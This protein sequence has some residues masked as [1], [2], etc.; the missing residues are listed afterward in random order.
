[1]IR[2][3]IFGA[4]EYS[5]TKNDFAW[6]DWIVSRRNISEIVTLP[7]WSSHMDIEDWYGRKQM[8]WWRSTSL[9]GAVSRCTAAAM[10][11]CDLDTM[12]TVI[13]LQRS[14]RPIAQRKESKGR[15]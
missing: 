8:P 12:A 2:L 11:S 7:E 13:A 4:A 10:V 5:L 9:K 15:K 14:G 3:L 6:I 1:M